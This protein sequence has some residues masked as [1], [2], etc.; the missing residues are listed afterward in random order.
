MAIARWVIFVQVILGRKIYLYCKCNLELKKNTLKLILFT[1]LS[2]PNTMLK[3][4]ANPAPPP[5]AIKSIVS[6]WSF[7]WLIGR[8]VPLSLQIQ[9]PVQTQAIYN[10]CQASWANLFASS[11]WYFSLCPTLSCG[12]NHRLIFITLSFEFWQPLFFLHILHYLSIANFGKS[13][14]QGWLNW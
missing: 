1:Y 9:C 8:Y 5:I 6:S 13:N 4:K 3:S 10:Y 12:A 14:K 7:A 2:W 11:S